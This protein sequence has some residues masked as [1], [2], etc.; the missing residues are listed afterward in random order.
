MTSFNELKRLPIPTYKEY[1]MCISEI[2]DPSLMNGWGWFVD[3]ELNTP[4]HFVQNN[5]TSHKKFSRIHSMKNLQNI[6]FIN[7]DNSNN[8]CSTI[9]VN[10]VGIIAVCI[11]YF[12]LNN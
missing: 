3:I 10:G 1:C 2:T 4:I 6:S 5:D 12:I 7:D 11:G 9:I 8:S